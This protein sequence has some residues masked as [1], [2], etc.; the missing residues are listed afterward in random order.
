VIVQKMPLKKMSML[1]SKTLP[2]N[3]NTGFIEEK[4]YS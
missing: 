1:I 4:A 3:N 2:F